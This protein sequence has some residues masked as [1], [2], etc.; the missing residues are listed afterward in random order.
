MK[1]NYFEQYLKLKPEKS[2][3]KYLFILDREELALQIILQGFYAVCLRKEE[4]EVPELLQIMEENLFCGTYLSDKIYI[5]CLHSKKENE[6][7]ID[8]CKSQYLHC[9]EGYWLFSGK[10]YLE[11]TFYEMNLKKRVDDFIKRFEGNEEEPDLDYYHKLSDKGK[12]TAPFDIRIVEK[13]I[14]AVPLFLLNG[15]PYVY[16]DGVYVEDADSAILKGHIQEY[17]YPQ[18][19]KHNILQSLSNLL[20]SRQGLAKQ[21]YE[22]NHHPKHWIHFKNGFLDVLERKMYPSDPAYYSM[23]QL[24]FEFNLE[25]Y[26]NMPSGE[27][28]ERFLAASVPDE[29]DRKMMWQYA[30]YCMT[31]DTRFQ[32]FLMMQGRGGTGKSVLISVIQHMIGLRNCASISLQDLNRRFYPTGLF[33]KLLNACADISSKAMESV[34]TIKKAVGEDTL[35]YEKKGKDATQFESYAK[36]LYS[37]NE[38]PMNQDE[39]SN[40]FYRRLMILE[41][42]QVISPEKRE[43]NLK[44]KLFCEMPYI[45]L[46]S[47]LALEE[48]YQEGGFS[49]SENSKNAV[50]DLYRKADSIKAFLEDKVEKKEGNV[51]RRSM[52]Y[53]VYCNYCEEKERQHHKKSRFFELMERKGFQTGRNAVDGVIYENVSLKENEFEPLPPNLKTPFE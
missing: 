8:F 53:E 16:K 38:L 32:K 44:E 29:A 1:K 34:D 45:I 36:L 3:D 13:V 14:T 41:M 43:Q 27:T 2:S 12:P 19:I 48:V 33:C 22:L 40:A 39:K 10:E 25:W 26:E 20:V 11:K 5:P 23:N 42:D 4:F 31:T 24:P 47:V 49:E 30:G 51:I 9:E 52:M 28:M 46:Q 35:L 37:A 17:L 6:A 18:F 50:N 7:I 21:Y 15:I